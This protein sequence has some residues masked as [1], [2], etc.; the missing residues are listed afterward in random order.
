[1]QEDCLSNPN[2]PMATRSF[3]D[4]NLC[5]TSTAGLHARQSLIDQ[6]NKVYGQERCDS[7]SS[8]ISYSGFSSSDAKAS[9][10]SAATP[11]RSS[12]VWGM[13]REACTS[14]SPKNTP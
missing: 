13:S 4:I 6:M 5:E 8:S 9:S 12:R 1:M 11:G 7:N 3:P 10:V 2:S 14:A